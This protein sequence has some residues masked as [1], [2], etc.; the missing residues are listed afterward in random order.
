MTPFI[1]TYQPSTAS[2]NPVASTYSASS[3][4]ISTHVTH[5]SIW[6]VFSFTDNAVK[7]LVRSAFNSVFGAFKVTDPPPICGGSN[8][9][10]ST[11][12]PISGD[13]EVCTQNGSNNAGILKVKSYLAFPIDVDPP[14]GSKVSVYPPNGLF[15]EIGGFISNAS[16]GASSGTVI[17]A[18]SEADVTAN[19]P[20]G[21]AQQIHSS[22]DMEAYLSGIIE[23]G[24]NVLTVM[25]KKLGKNP[26]ATLDAI[27]Q[28]KCAYELG[29][30]TYTNNP[31]SVETLKGLTQVAFDCAATVVELGTAGVV[32]GIIGTVTGLIENLLQTA[33]GAAILIVGGPAGTDTTITMSHS[34][35]APVAISC[36][37]PATA[38]RLFL[39]SGAHDIQGTE[40]VE[41]LV[42]QG[43]WGQGTIADAGNGAGFAA[44]HYVDGAWTYVTSAAFNSIY[45]DNLR[46]AGGPAWMFQ[47]CPA[48]SPV[49][50]ATTSLPPNDISGFV[51]S[52]Y[53]HGG[54]L[55]VN[56]DGSAQLT[57]QIYSQTGGSPTFPTLDLTLS[58][59]DT[60]AT[61]TATVSSSTDPTVAVGSTF[62]LTLATPGVVLSNTPGDMSQN[63]S[64][65]CDQTNAQQDLC[66]A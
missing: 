23:S 53:V 33:F 21:T 15:T 24:V 48:E 8:G 30:L 26:K 20:P 5:F 1:A 25:E 28:G 32:Q 45:C 64:E 9:L 16:K 59:S 62:T 58:G 29:Q 22:L 3:G 14:K 7:V 12:H 50:T 19:I 13:L 41:E 65:F 17:A 51:G 31:V 6:G 2:W 43:A 10:V 60:G 63:V 66:G 56:A 61:A 27:A 39:A 54:G 47:G 34:A 11:M 40:Q 57:F 44:F 38:T 35:S 49:A 4:T 42:C 55:Q 37:D 18:G 46:Q 36:I 52:W